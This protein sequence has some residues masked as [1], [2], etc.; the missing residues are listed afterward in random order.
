M[1]MAPGAR[2]MAQQERV[3]PT[4][5]WSS[6]PVP[7]RAVGTSFGIGANAI[8]DGPV[9][10]GETQWAPWAADSLKQPR[11]APSSAGGHESWDGDSKFIRRTPLCY[12]NT[13][14][15]KKVWGARSAMRRS[16]DGMELLGKL[17]DRDIF[18]V[19]GPAVVPGS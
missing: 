4:R 3:R 17:Q 12:K 5:S 8:L 9:L 16:L 2:G 14:P 13:W 10:V 19:S 1:G 11:Q 7:A 15:M 6:P 18:P